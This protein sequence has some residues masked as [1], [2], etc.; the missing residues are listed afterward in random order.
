MAHR[1][2]R[3]LEVYRRVVRLADDIHARVRVWSAFDRWTVGGQLMRAAD[4]AGANIAEAYGRQTDRDRRRLLFVA[5]GSL[6][7]LQH[8]LDRG[9]ARELA[10]PPDARSEAAEITRMLNGLLQSFND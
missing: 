9:S 1:G 6:C 10:L 5:R 3:E 2:F 4:S 8:W 7:E